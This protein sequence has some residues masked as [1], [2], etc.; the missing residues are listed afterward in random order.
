MYFYSTL[1]SYIKFFHSIACLSTINLKH[2]FTSSKVVRTRAKSESTGV[3]EKKGGFRLSY[4]I[5]I[6]VEGIPDLFSFYQKFSDN[7]SFC[8][9]CKLHFVIVM[10]KRGK[11]GYC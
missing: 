2:C 11:K 8:R 5:Y 7:I 3:E 1:R 6:I 10:N 9:A 4:K